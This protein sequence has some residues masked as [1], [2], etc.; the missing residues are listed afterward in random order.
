MNGAADRSARIGLDVLDQSE[1]RR[2]IERPWFLRFGF[3][4]E[5]IAHADTLG[6][7]RRLEFLAGRF[8]AK[9]ALC[10]MLG[11]GFLQGV[12]PREIYVEHTPRG[13]P[14]VHLRG[15]AAQYG[16]SCVS[17]SITHKQD[18]VAAVALGLPSA[19]DPMAESECTGPTEPKESAPMSPPNT[20]SATAAQRPAHH[21]ED[22]QA[23]TITAFLRVRIGQEEAHY[24]GNLVDGARILRLFGDL[25]T[26]ITVRTDGDEGLLAQYSG[27]QFTAPVKPGDYIEARGRLVRRTRLRRV[28]QLEA[29]KVLH[30]RPGGG[31]S[32]ATVLQE[33]QLVCSATA[34]SVVPLP[35]TR[36]A[37]TRS[38]AVK[39]T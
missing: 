28:V 8:A 11:T 15:R 34:T 33:P 6:A 31:E 7:E 9:E 14:V 16:P 12:T 18:I 30:A 2:L 22:A 38:S 17:V 27:I 3:T 35:R 39:E 32:A 4:P 1:L 26:E 19:A 20:N 21:E 10:K 23:P 29:H 36:P 13:A 5:E 24:G 25:V 37:A